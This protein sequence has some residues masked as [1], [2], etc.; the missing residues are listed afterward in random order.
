VEEKPF[1]SARSTIA[2]VWIKTVDSFDSLTPLIVRDFDA[3]E[4]VAVS[5]IMLTSSKSRSSLTLDALA[6]GGAGG[7]SIGFEQVLSYSAEGSIQE[8]SHGSRLLLELKIPYQDSALR[9]LTSVIHT[10][11]LS[12]SED[13]AEYRRWVLGLCWRD[14]VPS[15][16][17]TSPST[18]VFV[19]ESSN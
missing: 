14:W 7:N 16:V 13:R 9:E 3:I 1:P 11:A 5:D 12:V 17:G 2:G 6:L 4:S 10:I 19:R 15:G 8:R 18:L